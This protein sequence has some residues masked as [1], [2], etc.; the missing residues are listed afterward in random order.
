MTA[1]R[2][3]LGLTVLA[4]IVLIAIGVA[5]LPR[6]SSGDPATRLTAAQTS[7]LLA[8]S[9]GPLAAL[10]AQAGT[11]L[12]GGSPVLHA[13]LAALKGYPVVIN[14]W[15]SWCVPCQEESA[16]FQRVSAEYGRRVAFIGID[17][18]DSNR[19]DGAA[20]LK[21]FPVSYPSY[22]DKSGSLGLQLTDSTFRPATVFIPAHGRP[23]IRDGEYPS[24]ARLRRDVERYALAG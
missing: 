13:R 23:Y 19:A 5:Q 21:S 15:A 16:A 10:H 6:S 18:E 17:S 1:R 14:K 11:L 9:P 4:L 2:A 20:F 7:A 3:L 22:Y 12:E 24:A 8:G